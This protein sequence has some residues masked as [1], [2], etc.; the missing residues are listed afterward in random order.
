[1]R[2]IILAS[3]IG[4]IVLNSCRTNMATFEAGDVNSTRKVLVAGESSAFKE[5]VVAGLIDR[6]GTRDW[7]FRIIGLNQLEKE[8]TEPYGAI[9][10]VA[11][12]RAGRLDVR[13]TSYL[14]EDPQNPKTIVFFTRGSEDPLPEKQKPDLRIDAVSSASRDDQVDMRADQLAD[15][16]KRRF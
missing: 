10:L 6:L 7:Y 16:V 15:L 11:A 12:Y 3:L 8:N 14:R 2:R 5:R 4:V 13:V 1:M 9:L